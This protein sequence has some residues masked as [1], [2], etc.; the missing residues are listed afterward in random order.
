M[1]KAMID[2]IEKTIDE[3]YHLPRENRDWQMF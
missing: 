2:V 1:S 3:D